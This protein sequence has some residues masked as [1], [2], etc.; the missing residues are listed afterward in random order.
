MRWTSASAIIRSVNSRPATARA[1]PTTRRPALSTLPP[2]DLAPRPAARAAREK[3]LEPPSWAPPPSSAS[4][5]S[6]SSSSSRPSNKSPTSK[7][8]SS[9]SVSNADAIEPPF[10]AAA[11]ESPA[12]PAAAAASPASPA[13]AAASAAS[14]ASPAPGINCSATVAMPSAT[15]SSTL[16][17][18]LAVLHWTLHRFASLIKHVP[19]V[20][21]MT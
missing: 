17:I 2:I 21:S 11:A 5:I 10:S 16:S 1:V 20:G 4:S 13:A 14:A 8:S 15:S 12:S 19:S 18:K 6:S 9:S 3:M 7:I